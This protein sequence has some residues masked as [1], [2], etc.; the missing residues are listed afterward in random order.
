M[1]PS[2]TLKL[3]ILFAGMV[4]VMAAQLRSALRLRQEIRELHG[5]RE[6][7]E[8]THSDL[9]QA[10][11]ASAQHESQ[12]QSLRPEVV[13][14]RSELQTVRHELELAKAPTVQRAI[15]RAP[16]P[17]RFGAAPV[18]SPPQA[19]GAFLAS[20]HQRQQY[21]MWPTVRTNIAPL[22]PDDVRAYSTYFW[23]DDLELGTGISREAVLS[24]PDW[25]PSQP[26]P[27]SFTDA[28][29]V[30]RDELSKL[31]HNESAWEVSDIHLHRLWDRGST[32]WHYSVTLRPTD[33]PGF[34]EHPDT[35]TA[36]VALSGRPGVT[37][38]RDG[39]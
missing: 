27:L 1:K 19:D 26:L 16:A 30:A 21:H 12:A 11:Q 8:Q 32:K 5:V 33:R 9:E 37:G 18:L 4:T 2:T 10:T 6:L 22:S 25:M 20:L 17:D 24:S 39:R 36:H 7:A 14:L 28:E 15:P 3:V 23:L 13:S 38:L 29:Q 31:A 35:F 34:L